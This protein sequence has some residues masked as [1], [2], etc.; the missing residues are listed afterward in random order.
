[1]F[2]LGLRFR[3]GSI[4]WALRVGLLLMVLVGLLWVAD[5][6]FLGLCRW[7]VLRF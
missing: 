3:F 5:L 6:M 1:M 2:G 7:F 4:F